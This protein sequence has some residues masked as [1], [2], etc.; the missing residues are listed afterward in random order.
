MIAEEVRSKQ[1]AVSGLQYL[2]A[3]RMMNLSVAY[4]K[5][6]P[7]VEAGDL[8]AVVISALG[9]ILG[10]MTKDDS[11]ISPVKSV[12]SVNNMKDASK[13]PY[14]IPTSMI[15]SGVQVLIEHNEID[16]NVEHVTTRRVGRVLTKMRLPNTRLPGSNGK[17]G[18]LISFN[19]L[20]RWATGY[21]IEAIKI[22]GLQSFF[23]HGIN[24]ANGLN[25]ADGAHLRS[26]NRKG[27][28]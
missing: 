8:T 28:L 13:K 21:G 26:S 24:G 11:S 4:Q 1:L 9:I 6:R 5:E 22:T 23:T 18:W 16:I 25:G 14:F 20:D 10:K 19:D 17:R 7:N 27:E 2:L 12:S 15:T 3:T